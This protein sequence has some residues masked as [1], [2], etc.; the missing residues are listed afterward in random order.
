MVL[1]S[2]V[3]GSSGCYTRDAI[4]YLTLSATGKRRAL[5]AL[6]KCEISRKRLGPEY[7]KENLSDFDKHFLD[8]R[9]GNQ[10]KL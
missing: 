6:Q 2:E 8:H 10:I 4:L 9:R 1:V 5:G 7:A 3:R